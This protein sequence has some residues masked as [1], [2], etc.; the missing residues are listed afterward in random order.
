MGQTKG[1]FTL[2]T[3]T[4]VSAPPRT[5][6]RIRLRPFVIG[7]VI[8]I[9]L[10]VGANFGYN[11]WRDTTLYVTTDDALVDSNMAPIAASGTGTLVVWRVKPGDKVRTGQVIGVIRPAPSASAPASINVQAP[12]DGTVLR[13]DGEEGQF[14][15]AAQPLA[16]VADL[17][18]LTITAYIDETSIHK[19]QPG[20]Q[21]DVT[22]DASGSTLYQGTVKEILPATASQFALLQTID[23]TTANFTKVTQ[24]VEVHIDLGSTTTSRLYPG[25]SAY[26][27]IHI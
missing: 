23:R 3:E 22:V 2:T 7:L 20:Q 1:R 26:V 18:H 5:Q 10:A 6:P 16:Y 13:V 14:V 24:R 25:E 12:V 8:L 17:N 19:I 4:S 27:R 15:G 21:V 11:Y 9:V